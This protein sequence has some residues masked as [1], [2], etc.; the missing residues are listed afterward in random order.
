MPMATV[1]VVMA[2][3][4]AMVAMGEVVSVVLVVAMTRVVSEAVKLWK[5]STQSPSWRGTHMRLMRPHLQQL[6]G[7]DAK[8]PPRPSA[9]DIAHRLTQALYSSVRP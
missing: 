7:W 1:T 5:M 4:L 8:G 6:Q 9:G 2:A 3:T